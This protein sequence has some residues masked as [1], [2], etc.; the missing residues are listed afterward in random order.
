MNVYFIRFDWHRRA[1]LVCLNVLCAVSFWLGHSH[2][3]PLSI[4]TIFENRFHL[5]RTF[6][7]LFSS[8]HLIPADICVVVLCIILWWL[9]LWFVLLRFG[10]TSEIITFK[11]KLYLGYII[12]VN[13]LQFFV[14]KNP[15]RHEIFPPIFAFRPPHSHNFWPI[16][17]WIKLAVEWPFVCQR[18]QCIDRERVAECRVQSELMKNSTMAT[19]CSPIAW[20]DFVSHLQSSSYIV[21]QCA[22]FQT[23]QGTIAFKHLDEERMEREKIGQFLQ[24]HGMN[25][26]KTHIHRC[27]ASNSRERGEMYSFLCV[28]R[29]WAFVKT[30]RP[31]RI[32]AIMSRITFFTSSLNFI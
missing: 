3:L 25:A 15:K 30:S 1:C 13:I 5:I 31:N 22:Q 10:W 28:S 27:R 23:L 32:H 9:L 24:M 14:E 26:T 29:I 17:S 21:L 8:Y 12:S 16:F 7:C 6:V 2:V 18:L 4:F 11:L 19:K 20:G